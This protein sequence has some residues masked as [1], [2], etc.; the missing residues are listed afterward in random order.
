MDTNKE[1]EWMQT[2]WMNRCKMDEWIQSKVDEWM[3]TNWM[4]EC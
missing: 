1:D 4:N 3:E 2:K